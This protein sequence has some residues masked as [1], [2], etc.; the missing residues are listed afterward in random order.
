MKLIKTLAALLF[1]LTGMTGAMAVDVPSNLI[2]NAGGMEWAWASPCAPSAPS[3]GADLVMHDGWNLASASD[4]TSSFTGLTDLSAQFDSGAKCASAYFNSG[5]SNCDN[6]DV[7]VGVV[8][9]L[10]A[11]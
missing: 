8:W 1:G 3:C 7:L 11:A 2:V 4:F 9:N 10:P 5:W 6:S